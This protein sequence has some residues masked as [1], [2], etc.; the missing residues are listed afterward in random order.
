VGQVDVLVLRGDSVAVLYDDVN[1]GDVAPYVDID[2]AAVRL[3]LDLDD[4]STAEFVFDVPALPVGTVA[5]LF[6]VLD[7][8]GPF[9]FAALD[10]GSATL[11][12][13]VEEPPPPPPAP[14]NVRV[15]HLSPD[16]PAVAVRANDQSITDELS[17]FSATDYV[18]VA[19]GTA[20]LDVAL[21]ASPAAPILSVIG[22][23]LGE[24]SFTTAVAFGRAA[25]L[26][27]LTLADD[28]AAPSAGLARVRAVHVAVGIGA[29][30]VYAN[31]AKIYD[32]LAFGAAGVPL[33]V[34]ADS[35]TIGL[36]LDEDGHADVHFQLPALLAG[37]V[38]T[39]Y[40]VTDAH[41]AASLALQ[42]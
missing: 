38:A 20:D 3:G 18:E 16:A 27:V 41:G 8:T 13:V 23:A 1:Y 37:D 25:S 29:V 30:D 28:R 21:A 35:Y 19:A 39:L 11:R 17:F 42:L 6:A 33:E 7:Q 10:N 9:L 22:A 2:A 31:D 15:V 26:Q 12:P 4:D 34:P 40:A 5:T 36:D 32:D 14:A 24:G